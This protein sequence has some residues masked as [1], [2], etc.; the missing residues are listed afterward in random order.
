MGSKA[1]ELGGPSAVVGGPLAGAVMGGVG[2]L[3]DIFG[4]DSYDGPAYDPQSRPYSSP[5]AKYDENGA[6][7]EGTQWGPADYYKEKG[8]Q[9]TNDPQNTSLKWARD[10]AEAARQAT[11]KGA[12]LMWD[13]ATGAQSLAGSAAGMQR[14]ALSGQLHTAARAAGGNPA[15]GRASVLAGAQAGSQ[16]AGTSSLAEQKERNA[17]MDTYQGAVSNIRSSDQSMFGQ[18]A[19]R[20]KQQAAWN[21]TKSD[22][23]LEWWKMGLKDKEM[24]R[25]GQIAKDKLIQDEQEAIA[26]RRSGQKDATMAAAGQGMKTVT[27]VIRQAY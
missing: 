21:K 23:G 4:G 11:T 9:F 22:M 27:S 13:R 10:R 15:A 12:N 25:Q 18:E 8:D 3:M 6:Y 1:L 14:N 2:L 17:A 16:L 5:T 19:K 7:V 20:W 24:L 26:K